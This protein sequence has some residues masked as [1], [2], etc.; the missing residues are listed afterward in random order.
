MKRIDQGYA[1]KQE[2]QPNSNL[3][4]HILPT[5]ATMVGV[6]MTVISIIRLTRFSHKMEGM[7][8]QILAFDALFFLASAIASYL[9]IRSA[10]RAEWLE[11]I[12]D[13]VFLAGLSLMT[14]SA[15][16]LVYEIV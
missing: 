4:G 6:C 3:S 10:D 2:N 12:A 9:S 8:D 7:T 15:F 13:Q 11:R 5:S 1:M 16:F 14:I